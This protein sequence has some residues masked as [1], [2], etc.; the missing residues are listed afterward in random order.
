LSIFRLLFLLGTIILFLL[1]GAAWGQ[2]RTPTSPGPNKQLQPDKEDVKP[3]PDGQQ[4]VPLKDLREKPLR[5]QEDQAGKSLKN[6]Q[7]VKPKSTVSRGKKPGAGK[8]SSGAHQDQFALKTESDWWPSKLQPAP[9]SLSSL[10]LS[11]RQDPEKDSTV[12][13]DEPEERP[14]EK[15]EEFENLPQE[16]KKLTKSPVSPQDTELNGD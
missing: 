1:A 11:L 6:Q 15:G 10:E 13:E 12:E 14:E 5:A 3:S 16:L 9:P 8:P 2:S 7:P 4:D